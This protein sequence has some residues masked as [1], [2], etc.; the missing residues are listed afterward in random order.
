MWVGAR[1]SGCGLGIGLWLGLE[2]FAR[3]GKAI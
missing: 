2:I 1:G 3:I